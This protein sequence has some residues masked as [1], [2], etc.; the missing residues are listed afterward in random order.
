LVTIGSNALRNH[1]KRRKKR[2]MI[3]VSIQIFSILR[4]MKKMRL[5]RKMRMMILMSRTMLF[6]LK[7]LMSI[8]T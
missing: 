5:E 2:L 8:M 6:P 3:Q 7:T 4:M 1:Q